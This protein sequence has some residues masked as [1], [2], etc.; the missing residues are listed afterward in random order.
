MRIVINYKRHHICFETGTDEVRSFITPLMPTVVE[1]CA[2]VD[3][4]TGARR[5]ATLVTDE[6]RARGSS[7]RVEHDEDAC[8]Y[9]IDEVESVDHS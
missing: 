6:L 7:V 5:A 3:K 9:V 1:H 4:A 8:Q 2:R